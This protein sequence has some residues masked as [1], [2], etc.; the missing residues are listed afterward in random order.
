MTPQVQAYAHALGKRLDEL[1]GMN[2]VLR[3]DINALL[4]VYRDDWIEP[5]FR[6][7]FVRACWAYIEAIVYGIKEMTLCAS[8]LGAADLPARDLRFLSGVTYVVS[9]DGVIEVKIIRCDTE[10]NIRRTLQVAAYCFGVA[11]P[12]FNQKEGRL[13]KYSL[14]LRHRLVHP[15]SVIQL[16]VTTQEMENHREVFIW[17]AELFTQFLSDMQSV[18]LQ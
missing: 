6:R 7:A 18:T 12:D 1:L 2:A 17:F 14:Q 5:A 4:D 9:S 15:K 8:N 16:C 3:D 13:L 11:T 10:Q